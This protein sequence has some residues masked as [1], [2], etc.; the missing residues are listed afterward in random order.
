MFDSEKQPLLERSRRIEEENEISTHSL[1]YP[2][3][4]KS[5]I[6]FPF[7]NCLPISTASSQESLG[8][9]TIPVKDDDIDESIDYSDDDKELPDL[10]YIKNPVTIKGSRFSSHEK[11]QEIRKLM[12]KH[13]IG[14]YIIPSEDEHISENTALA[15]KRRE[16]IS[17]FTGSAG[18]AII[19]VTDED[20]LSG[21]AI[22]STDGRYFLQAQ[23]QLDLKLWKLNKQGVIGYTNWTQLTINLATKNSFSKTISCDPRTLSLSLGKFFK[24]KET[25]FDFKFLPTIEFNLV[26]KVWGDEKPKRSLE[27]VYL[28]NLNYSGEHTNHKLKRIREIMEEK[29]ATHYVVTELDSIAWLFNLRSDFDIPFA[30]VFF[31]YTIITLSSV[32][33]FINKKKIDKGDQELKDY[34]STI[35]GLIINDYDE[36]YNS[37]SKLKGTI[38][39]S[40][41]M[42]I[43]PDA[44]ASTLAL[45]DSIPESFSKR[46]IHHESIIAKLKL[47]KNKTESFNAKIA[48]YKDSLAFVL[49]ISWLEHQLLRKKKK[50]SEYDAACKIFGIREKLP[51]FKGLSYEC[52]S[53]SG[54]NAAIIHYSPTKEENSIIDPKK[55]YLL[56]AGAHYLEGTTDITRTY[57]FDNSAITKENKKHYTLVLKGHLAVAMAKFPANSKGTGVVLDSYAR[58]PLWNH[59]LDFNHGV[60]HGIGSF[61]VVHEGPISISSTA[62]GPDK[63]DLFKS[64]AIITDEPGYYIDGECGYRVE[65][66]IEVI[67]CDESFGKT[68][69]GGNFLG[70]EYLTKVPFCLN[71]VDTT[72]LSEIEIK[73]INEYHESIREDF[74]DKLLKLNNKRAY[75]WLMR[76]T[77]PIEI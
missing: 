50:I 18:V 11:L 67:E 59:G 20:S 56:D 3:F 49:L 7:Q 15:D 75:R 26:D 13:D 29:N 32:E 31:A 45:Y 66:E 24:E 60:G 55:P 71:L 53:S 44:S 58:Q 34:I 47:Y 25:Y 65:S 43:L 48:Q 16:Y 35:E 51:N 63:S 69:N 40:N 77:S 38:F 30:P 41:L 72:Y 61:G 9:E 36:F 19:T 70:F 33:L 14:V 57:F 17:G 10:P 6:V 23:N 73:W 4:L 5:L 1:K 74:A 12:V 21:E 54:A 76:E 46:K 28:L 42:I 2:S 37:T 39:D 62:G 64:G 52:I 27:P 8:I 22:L 68:K